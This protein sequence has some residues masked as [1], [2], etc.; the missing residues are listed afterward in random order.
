LPTESFYEV[1]TLRLDSRHLPVY[2][3][4]VNGL[5]VDTGFSRRRE[6]VRAFLRETKPTQAVV[7][8]HHEDHSG[9]VATLLQEGLKVW[10]PQQALEPIAK[11]FKV[12]LYRWR[13]WGYPEH[14][15][16]ELL[17]EEIHAGS[18]VLRAVHAPGHS[19]D[20][21][22]LHAPERGWIFAGDLFISRRL[23]FL[24]SDEDPNALIRSLERVLALDFE[25]LFCAHR[26]VIKDGRAQ[27]Q[28]K[29]DY[30]TGLRQQVLELSRQG[31]SPRQIT[32]R[33]LGRETSMYFIT[34]GKFS[35]INFVRGFLASSPAASR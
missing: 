16:C 29:L 21:T 30:L 25:T 15:A 28:A 14:A 6:L 35:A 4:C 10:A 32:R 33:V 20:M 26:G 3:Y 31:L 24:R 18:L 34:A 27:L 17:P 11:G 7:T 1:R 5:L 2:L 9:N 23:R 22:V 19:E 12:E 13:I 8:H